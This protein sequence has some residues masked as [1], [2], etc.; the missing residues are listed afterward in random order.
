VFLA[1]QLTW[2]GGDPDANDVLAYDVYFG[3]RYPLPLVSQHQAAL[4]YDPGALLPNVTYY[5]QVVAWD[6]AGS[7][8]M[9]APWWFTTT[10]LPPHAPA[11]PIPADQAT[12]AP[13]TVVLCWTG[14]DPNLDDPVTYDVRLGTTVPPPLVCTNLTAT[15]YD[16]GALAVDTTYYW[17]IVARDGFDLSTE[18]PMWSF[19][20]NRQPPLVPA[21]PAPADGAVDVYPN[22]D[23]AWTGG[24]SDVGDSVTYDVYFGSALP[25][26]LVSEGQAE[27]AF[28]LP[29][30]DFDATCYWQIVAHDSFGLTT[31]GPVWQFKT[32]IPAGSVLHVG[33]GPDPYPTIQAA[34]AAAASGDAIVAHRDSSPYFEHVVVSKQLMLI[35]ESRATTVIDGG[36]AGV[37]V[38]IA[39]ASQ[40]TVTGFTLQNGDVGVQVNPPCED[41]W[42]GC[43]WE[44]RSTG[45][46]IVY[47]RILSDEGSC[48]IVLYGVDYDSENNC[49]T[50]NA[51]GKSAWPAPRNLIQPL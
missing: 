44:G 42:G 23:L 6:A 31:T 50:G 30:L 46:T 41:Q 25:P 13:L 4:T 35:G 49:V 43:G 15:S 2:T 38:Y 36:G 33:G 3:T 21:N 17:Q 45:N 40:V 26:A 18:G 20:T 9:S 19:D 5:W 16:P 39:G 29:F 8:T 51:V 27:A 11:E 14:G 24:D 32:C 37:V 48:G 22:I 34:I 47:N 1:T 28:D 10:I 7:S 12:G